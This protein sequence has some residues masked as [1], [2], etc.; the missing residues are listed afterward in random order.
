MSRPLWLPDTDVPLGRVLSFPTAMPEAPAVQSELGGA[1]TYASPENIILQATQNLAQ[2]VRLA[3]S[4]SEDQILTLLGDL[5]TFKMQRLEPMQLA[6]EHH[7]A[8]LSDLSARQARKRRRR[9][10]RVREKISA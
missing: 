7:R 9:Q 5:L 2:I 1:L 3:H 4:L 10:R 6:V 8:F